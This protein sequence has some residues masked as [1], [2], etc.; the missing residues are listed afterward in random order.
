LDINDP[1]QRE[2]LL[3]EGIIDDDEENEGNE[4]NQEEK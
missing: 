3:A 1:K 2:I 4:E